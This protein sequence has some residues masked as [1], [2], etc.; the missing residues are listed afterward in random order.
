[1]SSKWKEKWK[2]MRMICLQ[3][4]I[5]LLLTLALGALL[6]YRLGE[7]PMTAVYYI[8]DGAFGSLY[9]FGSTLRWMTPCLFT[10]IAVSFA[11]KSGIFNCGIQGQV[12]M[13]AITAATICSADAS[14]NSCVCLY[15]SSRDCRNAM[16]IDSCNYEII[17]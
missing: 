14:R 6:I 15:R 1:M 5:A 16:G 12:Y 10:G 7:Q 9:K 11:F 3:Y 13:G 17:F 8:W 2:D 4:V